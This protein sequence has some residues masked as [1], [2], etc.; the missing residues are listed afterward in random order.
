[1]YIICLPF[2]INLKSFSNQL[3]GKRLKVEFLS[4]DEFQIVFELDG[5]LITNKHKIYEDIITKWYVIKLDVFQNVSTVQANYEVEF[6]N[7]NYWI[8]K[9]KC[10]RE[11][12]KDIVIQH[13]G[14]VKLPFSIMLPHRGLLEW[15]R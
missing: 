4:E 15:K 7:K 8:N 9:E 3:A 13:A 5:E 2:K 6:H 1:M 14:D 11:E 10:S 12:Q